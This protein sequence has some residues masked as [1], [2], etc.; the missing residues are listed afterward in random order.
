KRILIFFFFCAIAVLPSTCL[1]CRVLMTPVQLR[2]YTILS[3]GHRT[4]PLEISSIATR[5]ALSKPSSRQTWYDATAVDEDQRA[6][7]I[8]PNIPLI[9]FYGRIFRKT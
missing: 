5:V 8:D 6:T 1:S 9:P 4:S 7:E 3:G 2:S